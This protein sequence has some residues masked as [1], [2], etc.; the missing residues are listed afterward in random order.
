MLEPSH[1]AKKR[2]EENYYRFIAGKLILDSETRV[3]A[4]KVS[5]ISTED[6]DVEKVKVR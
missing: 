1:K 5:N 3:V 4:I 2:S 6:I